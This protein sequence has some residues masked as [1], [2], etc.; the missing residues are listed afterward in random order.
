MNQTELTQEQTI[1][2]ATE[3][4]GWKYQKGKRNNAPILDRPDV[5]NEN[6]G[7]KVFVEDWNPS[8][9]AE[10]FRELEDAFI[11][12]YKI[13]K[14][15]FYRLDNGSWGAKYREPNQSISNSIA[16]TK[17]QASLNAILNKL[18]G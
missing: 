11:E 16:E 8:T 10:Q 12:K 3:I 2:L 9:N 14:I 18:E 1:K 5:F 6:G 17:Q 7:W 4:M 13:E 15:S